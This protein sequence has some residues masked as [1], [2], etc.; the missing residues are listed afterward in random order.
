MPWIDYNSMHV[1]SAKTHHGQTSL[2]AE[3]LTLYN[4]IVITGFRDDEVYEKEELKS[5]LLNF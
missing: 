4:L 1:W 2:A 5:K 3:Y